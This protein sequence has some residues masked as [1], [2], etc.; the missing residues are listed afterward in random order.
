MRVVA[1]RNGGTCRGQHSQQAEF[2]RHVDAL[3]RLA[4]R[5]L[6]TETE[7]P[8]CTLVLRSAKSV[9]ARAIAQTYETLA[10][11][12]IAVKAILTKIEPEQELHALFAN[13]SAL[14][15]DGGLGAE[16]GLGAHIRW[17]RNPRLLDAHEQAV[18]GAE[19][20]WTGDAVRRDADKRNRLVLFQSEPE[21]ILR[22][23]HAF[24]ALWAASAPVPA[25]L[26]SRPTGDFRPS[27]DAGAKDTPLA[28]LTQPA[29][30]WPLLRH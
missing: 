20:C 21:A 29:E 25:H 17:A 18:Y 10:T 23:A 5:G 8:I 24:K 30:G 16:A 1:E 12:G 11:A 2:E 14:L 19:L 9:P 22:G 7:K 3:S 13:L 15:P 4:E 6:R 28:G 27:A 26:L